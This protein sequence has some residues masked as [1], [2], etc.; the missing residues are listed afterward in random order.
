MSTIRICPL[1][2]SG[3]ILRIDSD[4]GGVV[5]LVDETAVKPLDRKTVMSSLQ[6]AST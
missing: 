3:S 2:A 4:D 1:T 6:F 5:V